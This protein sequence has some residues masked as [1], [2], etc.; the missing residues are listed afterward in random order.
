MVALLLYYNKFVKSLNSK[1]FKL[2]PYDPCMANKQ[3]KGEQ[4]TVCFH[5]DNCK[6]SQLI[7]KVVDKTIDWLWSEYEHVFEGGTGEMKVH[8]GKTHNYLGMSLDFGR[9]I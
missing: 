4:L 2:N 3:V 7:P 9:D 1:G 5:V 8:C 6:I